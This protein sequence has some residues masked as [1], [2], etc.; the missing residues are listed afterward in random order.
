MPGIVA[1]VMFTEPEVE[2]NVVLAQ[3]VLAEPTNVKPAGNV[4]MSVAPVMFALLEL[5]RVMVRV[6]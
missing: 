4:S 5:L 1:P 3:V 2:V 6:D